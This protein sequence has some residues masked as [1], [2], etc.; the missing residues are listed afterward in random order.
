MPTESHRRLVAVELVD[1]PPPDNPGGGS[2]ALVDHADHGVARAG[3][4]GLLALLADRLGSDG[5][6]LAPLAPGPERE[7]ILTILRTDLPL[8][9]DDIAVVLPTSGSTGEP[10]G[11]LLPADALLHSARATLDALGGPGR[12]LLALPPTRVAGLQVLVR[13]LVAATTPVMMPG[14]F[15]V[16]AF[17]AATERLTDGWSGRRY[18]AVVPTQLGRLLDGGTAAVDALRSYDAV[19]AGGGASSAALLERARSAGVRVVTTY[20]MTETCGG[21]VYDG[22]PLAGVD[23]DV[24]EASGLVRIGGATVFAGYRRRPD[25]TAKALVDG[26]HLTS[27]LGRLGPDGT[28]EILGRADDVVV[29]GG[30]NVPL[31]AVERAVA[32]CPG[33]A[34]AAAVGVPDPEWGSRVRAYVVLRPGADAPALADVR[35]H[36]STAHPRAYAPR[37]VV[38]VDALPLLPSGK[39]DRSALRA[40]AG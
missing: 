4:D 3:V 13:S 8:E 17:T 30:V 22:R 27:D 34:E 29:S 28:L 1:E 37:E 23:L 40:A 26:R 5:P 24:D 14:R 35:D 7:Q 6:A 21:C 10:K 36:V 20:G 39:V 15:T 2:R 31:L 12:W 38:V 16:E 19:L 11:A 25:L 9:R 33:V 18:T 32:S